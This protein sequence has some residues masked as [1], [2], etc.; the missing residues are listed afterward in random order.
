MSPTNATGEEDPL[1]A[2]RNPAQL[3]LT[4]LDGRVV[5]LWRVGHGIGTAVLLALAVAGGAALGWFVPWAWP[6]IIGAW[7]VLLALQLWLMIWLPPLAYH[8]FGYG[9]D[10]KVLLIRSGIWWQTVQ[11][12]P[13]SR[14]Q[15]VD[16][17]SGPLER[18]FGLASLVLYTAGTHAAA[19]RIPGLDAAEAARLRDHLVAVG[20]DDAV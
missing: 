1:A 12:L 5:P 14:L 17:S 9:L 8:A 16:L 19:L 7:V 4:P 3:P 6:W 13:L 2:A 18:R 10:E 11:L 15:H 20:G